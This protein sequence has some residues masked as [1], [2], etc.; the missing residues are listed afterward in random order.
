MVADKRETINDVIR[1]LKRFWRY[2]DNIVWNSPE[3]T[4]IRDITKIINW[5]ETL[6]VYPH[7]E[8]SLL[9]E[10]VVVDGHLLGPYNS[11]V[12]LDLIEISFVGLKKREIFPDPDT[13]LSGRVYPRPA[14]I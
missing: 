4:T 2:E 5:N 6:R 9:S 13:L 11:L 14:I 3:V 7:S 8:Q 1:I 10:M 12:T